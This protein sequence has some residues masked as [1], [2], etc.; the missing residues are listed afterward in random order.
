MKERLNGYI[1]GL[2]ADAER[3]SPD[4]LRLAELKEELML[5]TCEKY[6]DLVAMGKTPEAAY[7]AAVDGIGDITELLRDMV[8]KEAGHE[9]VLPDN[10]EAPISAPVPMEQSE[11]TP[12]G[13]AEEADD[14]DGDEEKRPPRSRW[15]GLVSGIIWT[16]ILCAYF[17][18]SFSTRAWSVTWLLFLMGIAADNVAKCIFDLRR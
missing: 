3:R 18:L 17:L 1:Q 13:Q 7:R 6:D 10:G 12:D 9:E 15:Y 5:N 14:E 8:G 4:N 11:E 16:V 2:F